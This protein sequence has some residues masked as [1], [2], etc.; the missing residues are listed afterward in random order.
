MMATEHYFHGGW[1]LE[2]V[3]PVEPRH[4]CPICL[5]CQREPH[6]TSCG[7]RFCHSCIR[8]WLAEGRTC[9][10]DGCSLGEGDIFPDGIAEREIRQLAV[11][12]RACQAEVRLGELE[13]HL[14]ACSPDRQVAP[15]CQE[16]GEVVAAPGLPDHQGLVCPDSRV[17]CLFTGIGCSAPLLRKELPGH[18]ASQTVHH[19]QL[20]ADKMAKLQQ[21]QSAEEIADCAV[22]EAS[23]SPGSL[24]G[25]PSMERGQPVRLSGSNLHSSSKLL[26]ELY[27]RVVGLEQRNCQQEIRL[28]RLELRLAGLQ[29]PGESGDHP[30]GRAC[31]GV[32]VWT[33]PAFSA[34][35]AKMRTDHAFV[36]WSRG[37]YSSVFGY[38]LCLRASVT[39]RA[40]EEHLGLFLHLMRGE[41]DAAL[42][43]PFRG[44]AALGLVPQ[45]DGLLR[46]TF[47]ETMESDP[48]LAAFRRPR[49]ERSQAGFGFP[50]FI[51]VNSLYTNGFLGPTEDTLV[52][53][54]A[55]TCPRD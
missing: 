29:P 21:L 12:C 48:E 19:M 45:G 27:Q 41:S 9:P 32:F 26:R 23:C 18:L 42:V 1:D 7:H 28:G 10:E 38:R 15:G 6:Q 16:C 30:L 44:K 5:L 35:H 14:A 20:L 36:L 4:E 51:R 25:S 50:E 39:F 3:A 53:R 2:F 34:L 54:V 11:R 49:E 40:G 55:V 37:F 31:N 33:I 24:P 47:T 22:A 13:H 43:W 8:A 52:V 17:A 46:E